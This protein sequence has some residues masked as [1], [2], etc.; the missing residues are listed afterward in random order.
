MSRYRKALTGRRGECGYDNAP[1]TVLREHTPQVNS[2]LPFFLRL[3]RLRPAPSEPIVVVVVAVSFHLTYSATRPYSHLSA[4]ITDFGKT[5]EPR[6]VPSLR[7]V[8]ANLLDSSIVPAATPRS[9]ASNPTAT[10]FPPPT[11]SRRPILLPRFLLASREFTEQLF[12][13]LYST[14][15]A[16]ELF[17]PRLVSTIHVAF[18]V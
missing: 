16:K 4:S 5:V 1:A 17:Y 9:L 18:L 15:S 10:R 12:S 7:R 3:F 14:C 11:R 13:Q 8:R 6:R 2:L